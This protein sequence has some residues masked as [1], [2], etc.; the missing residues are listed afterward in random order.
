MATLTL[1][2]LLAPA[3]QKSVKIT[4]PKKYLRLSRQ[5]G[6]ELPPWI[7]EIERRGPQN[8][9]ESMALVMQRARKGPGNPHARRVARLREALEERFAERL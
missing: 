3:K 6:P 9:F 5:V 2:P 4:P 7:R 8:D 1:A